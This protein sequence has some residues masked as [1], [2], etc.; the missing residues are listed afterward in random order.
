MGKNTL[1]IDYYSGWGFVDFFGSCIK[2]SLTIPLNADRYEEDFDNCCFSPLFCCWCLCPVRLCWRAQ[3]GTVDK[4]RV[5]D[6]FQNQEFSEAIDYLS[7]AIQADSGNVTLL[8]WA[9]YVQL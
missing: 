3:S 5:M 6:Y 8:G 7:P 4:S 2:E 9:G 1:F